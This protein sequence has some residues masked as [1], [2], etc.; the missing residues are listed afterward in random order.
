MLFVPTIITIISKSPPYFTKHITEF[1]L[2]ANCFVCFSQLLVLK[3]VRF[4]ART[5][6][7]KTSENPWFYKVFSGNKIKLKSHT[8]FPCWKT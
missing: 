1:L 7:L 6:P 4:S 5:D 3:N 8:K 2:I